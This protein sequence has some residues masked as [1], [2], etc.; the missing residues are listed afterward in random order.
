[1]FQH[2]FGIGDEAIVNTYQI[3]A[4]LSYSLWSIYGVVKSILK[5]AILA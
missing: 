1:M 2:A 3:I 4:I 5:Q